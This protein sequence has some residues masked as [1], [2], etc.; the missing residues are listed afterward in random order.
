MTI[1]DPYA[2]QFWWVVGLAV[3]VLVPIQSATLRK[4][5]LAGIN[6][7]FL[8][9]AMKLGVVVVLILMVVAWAL[10]RAI[11]GRFGTA[12]LAVGGVATLAIFLEHK[13]PWL[14]V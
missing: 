13:L 9:L 4:W 3:V 6:L 1:L 5:V 2:V 11:A 8:V 12:A 14:G 10:L 7:G